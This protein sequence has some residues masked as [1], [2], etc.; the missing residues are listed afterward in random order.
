[1]ELDWN[2]RLPEH[3]VPMLAKA[4]VNFY[5]FVHG[6]LHLPGAGR[7]LRAATRFVPGLRA[8][9][10]PLPGI[11]TTVLDFREISAFGSVNFTLG[12][13]DQL[14]ALLH[15][16]ERCLAPGQV[17][18]DV[19]A[20]AGLVCI[21]FAQTRFGLAE[22]HGFEPNPEA[23]KPLQSLFNGHPRVHIHPFALGNANGTAALHVVPN[24]SLSGSLKRTPDGHATLQIQVRRGDDVQAELNLPLPHAIKIDV[25]GF[26]PEVLAGLRQTIAR[27]QPVIFFE[28][29]FLSDDEL[30]AAVPPG[31]GMFLVLDDGSLTADFAKKSLGHDA[32][33]FPESK[34]SLFDGVRRA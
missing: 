29:L 10:Y 9:P 4:L 24:D 16:L 30:R 33:V 32:V 19:G 15:L 22:I 25:E 2:I 28:Y 5:C 26:E 18:W 12:E 6:R 7:L 27:Q 17:L 8:Y 34:R 14:S 1:M 3:A 31:Y 13:T 23:L 11:G 20:N 21:H